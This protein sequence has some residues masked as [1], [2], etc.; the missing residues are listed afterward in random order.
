MIDSCD[1]SCCF[2]ESSKE[3]SIL[4]DFLTQQQDFRATAD[5]TVYKEVMKFL[6]EEC[7]T[8]DSGRKLLKSEMTAVAFYK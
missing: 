7:S 1:I 5:K 4:L 2:D 8:D 3:G 6:N